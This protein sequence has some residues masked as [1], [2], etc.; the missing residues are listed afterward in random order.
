M[1]T[2]DFAL[3]FH[4]TMWLVDSQKQFETNF[5]I[6]SLLLFMQSGLQFCSGGAK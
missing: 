1:S 6:Y 4:T 3:N 5:Q 2:L